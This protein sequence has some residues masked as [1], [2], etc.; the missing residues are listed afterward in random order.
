MLKS[1]KPDH[2]LKQMG[3]RENSEFQ[4]EKGTE[5]MGPLL[6]RLGETV[7]NRRLMV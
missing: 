4:S 6:S 7:R 5:R 2:T 1:N 3:V